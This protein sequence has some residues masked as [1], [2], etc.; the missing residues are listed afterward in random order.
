MSG[1]TYL[2]IRHDLSV[3]RQKKKKKK[4][5]EPDRRALPRQPG[6]GL[7]RPRASSGRRSTP[8][9]RA[10]LLD[11]VPDSR[12]VGARRKPVIGEIPKPHFA[13]T[14]L[15]LPSPL[16]TDWRDA[17]R[18]WPFR[19]RA[20]PQSAAL[21][22]I[23]PRAGRSRSEPPVSARARV[24]PGARRSLRAST[25]R[26]LSRSQDDLSGSGR[27]RRT[28]GF[29][30]LTKRYQVHSHQIFPNAFRRSSNRRS[31]CT[32]ASRSRGG[33]SRT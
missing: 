6:G 31:C 21:A 4:H 12:T 19:N 26:S 9:I 13:A 1:L 7:P 32:C 20:R 8:P 17:C 28:V 16:S 23:R 11:S 25:R 15:R 18:P 10:L 5:G 33:T 22:C 14:G 3:V 2:F 30:A 29:Q 24:V 27:S